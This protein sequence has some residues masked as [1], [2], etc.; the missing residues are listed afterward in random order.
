MMAGTQVGRASRMRAATGRA[1]AS[2]GDGR[3]RG[4]GRRLWALLNAQ[5]LLQGTAGGHDGAA[6]E[7]DRRRFAARGS[8]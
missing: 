3:G 2:R 8:G 1:A 4:A 5:G 7:D 6:A